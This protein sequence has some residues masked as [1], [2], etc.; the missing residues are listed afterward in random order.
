MDVRDQLT[1]MIER[2]YG[3]TMGRIDAIAPGTRDC[4]AGCRF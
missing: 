3:E 2:R 4:A 1:V